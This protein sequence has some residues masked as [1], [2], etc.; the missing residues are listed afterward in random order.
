MVSLVL[1]ITSTLTFLLSFL[2]FIMIHVIKYGLEQD[3]M[4]FIQYSLDESCF[5]ER[6]DQDDGL[7]RF[8]CTALMIPKVR[9][10]KGPTIEKLGITKKS[11]FLVLSS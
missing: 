4:Q 8:L 2:R 10:K 5:L 6:K 11:T 9:V 7:E 1:S 3:I